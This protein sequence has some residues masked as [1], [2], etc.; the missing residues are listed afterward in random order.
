MTCHIHGLLDMQNSRKFPLSNLIW[1]SL[2]CAHARSFAHAPSF[3]IAAIVMLSSIFFQSFFG[4]S[5]F[6]F[7]MK[8]ARLRFSGCNHNNRCQQD[9]NHEFFTH[10]KTEKT[11]I[12]NVWTRYA[13]R[14]T[15]TECCGDGGNTKQ[16]SWICIRNWIKMQSYYSPFAIK[17]NEQCHINWQPR[18]LSINACGKTGTILSNFLHAPHNWQPR[19][20][21][22]SYSCRGFFCRICLSFLCAKE[23]S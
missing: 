17:V 12:S 2:A 21:S 8:F 20:H 19:R 4:C 11:I 10:T 18:E 7:F 23:K 3:S 13:V 1:L 14:E 9:Q 6:F 15:A 5:G 16:F 22:W